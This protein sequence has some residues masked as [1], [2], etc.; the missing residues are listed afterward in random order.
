MNSATMNKWQARAFA[1]GR[2]DAVQGIEGTRTPC[3]LFEVV[4]GIRPQDGLDLQLAFVM[5]AYQ[6][7]VIF[8]TQIDCC[9]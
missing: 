6:T 9:G 4:A 5:D 2:Q 7:G 8:G 3:G 1:I